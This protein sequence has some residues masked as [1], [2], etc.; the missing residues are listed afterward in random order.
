MH[1]RKPEPFS[2]FFSFF[3]IYGRGQ[4]VTGHIV[5]MDGGY[6]EAVV[7]LLAFAKEIHGLR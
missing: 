6:V 4:F 3:F 5:N 7:K 2:V 1:T